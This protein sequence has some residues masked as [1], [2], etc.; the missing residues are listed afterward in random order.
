M[1]KPAVTAFVILVVV[2]LSASAAQT[3]SYY[4]QQ[5]QSVAITAI[6][7][8][9]SIV[10]L[11]VFA[12]FNV[13]S[14]NGFGLWY[15]L[16]FMLGL[17][18]VAC[19]DGTASRLLWPSNPE[20]TNWIPLTTLLALNGNGLLLAVAASEGQP[21]PLMK[22]LSGIF[23]VMGIISFVCIALIPFVPIIVL[24]LIANILFVPMVVSQLLSA[25][26]WRPSGQHPGERQFAYA[27]RFSRITGLLFLLA[28]LVIAAVGWH[29]M[30]NDSFS[31]YELSYT[32]V[33]LVYALLS[34]SLVA[35]YMAHII[36]IRKDHE[37]A[38]QR[39]LI[40]A[41][42]AAVISEEKLQAEREFARMR[43]LAARRRE[44]LSE[45]SHDIRQPLVSLKL[46]LDKLKHAVD[47]DEDIE[48]QRALEYI[49]R[50]AD[51]FM[52]TE[53]EPE[54]ELDKSAESGTENEIMPL[55][56]LLQTMS[57]MFS[58]EAGSKGIQLSTVPTTL[59]ALVNPVAVMRI[60]S[61][62]VSNAI[63]HSHS[64]RILVGCR[65]E[66]D[67]V[68]ID[69]CDQGKG[70]STEQFE[71]LRQRGVKGGASQGQGIGLASCYE[72]AEQNNYQFG[73]K[74]SPLN[75]SCVSLSVPR[76]PKSL[77]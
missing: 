9:S 62:M 18:L 59:N 10:L 47:L 24:A 61:N 64:Q 73:V 54:K 51:S 21:P 15:T 37:D 52:P 1:N 11:L 69:V 36:G 53:T 6:F 49:D 44:K 77:S 23:Q 67:R 28:V 46:T 65:R 27:G 33:R 66:G 32:A 58:E 26:S 35:T 2:S 68:R 7:Y 71:E 63:E 34:F 4:E 19:V 45:A 29:Q 41:R 50:L 31:Y 30:N 5:L 75:A 40:T 12:L 43:E 55:N 3:I 76:Y 48:Y 38:L 70:I 16:Q 39:E 8:A 72:L 60:T 14:R 22:K 17:F 42:R 20:L 13:A 74:T 25:M 57:Q 56:L